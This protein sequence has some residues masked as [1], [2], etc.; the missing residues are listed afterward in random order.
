MVLPIIWRLQHAG[1]TVIAYDNAT[2]IFLAGDP[3]LL[4]PAIRRVEADIKSRIAEFRASG[5]TEFGFFGTSLGSFILYD[6][7]STIPELKWGVFNTGG[8][9]AQSVWRLPKARQA[10]EAH[11]IDLPALEQAWREFQYCPF[12]GLSGG[13]YAFLGSRGDNIAPLADIAPYLIPIR[14]A[15]ATIG[16][17]EIGGT[18]HLRAA[19]I[20][21]WQASAFIAQVQRGEVGE[22][23]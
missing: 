13:R 20:G 9:L 1:H 14:D 10:F 8:N 15:G 2:D 7:L 6:C 22:R 18:T 11:H 16:I 21:L 23:L 19:I 5:I 17:I 4:E 12:S 3:T